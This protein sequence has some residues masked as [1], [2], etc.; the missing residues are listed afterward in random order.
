MS[1]IEIVALTVVGW[2]MPILL[3]AEAGAIK[4]PTPAMS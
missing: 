2:A 4:T 3:N 1:K